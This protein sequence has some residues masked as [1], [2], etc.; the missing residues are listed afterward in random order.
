MSKRERIIQVV[1]RISTL[2]AELDRLEREFAALVPEDDVTGSA[3]KSE[4]PSMPS[5]VSAYLS[6]HRDRTFDAQEIGKELGT[7]DLHL[8]R[9]TLFR[10]AKS[11]KIRKVKR[12]QYGALTGTED[13]AA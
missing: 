8:V 5:R 7:K 1:G 3:S 12:G 2:R 9:S 6:A 13:A 11:N 10:L 4:E